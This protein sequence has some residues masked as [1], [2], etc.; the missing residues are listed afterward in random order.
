V[1]A[2]LLVALALY[3]RV[4]RPL[5]L[6]H[7]LRAAIVECLRTRPHALTAGEVAAL[8]GAERKTVE[9]H[10]RYLAR[11]GLLRTT[12]ERGVV[13]HHAPGSPAAAPPDPLV[14]RL[15]DLVSRQPG[16]TTREAASALGLT[17]PRAERRL[18]D[19]CVQ[20]RLAARV[21]GRERRFFAPA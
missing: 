2:L 18:K 10:L 9:Y 19:L 20:G 15:L 4:A 17:R 11:L 8:V 3:Q 6:R 21:V 5:A 12:R 14:A 13:R 7:P 1:S 16:F